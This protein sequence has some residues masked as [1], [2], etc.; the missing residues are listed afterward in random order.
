MEG[1]DLGLIRSEK[2]DMGAVAHRRAA[3][4]D[5]SLNP[6][7]RVFTAP[8]D[9]AGVF[10]DAPAAKGGED[11]VVEGNRLVEAVAAQ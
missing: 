5:G 1:V 8:G 4:V 11:L 2:A 10:E 3:A 7:F 6:E 9:G